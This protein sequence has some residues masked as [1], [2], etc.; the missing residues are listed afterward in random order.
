MSRKIKTIEQSRFLDNDT[1]KELNGGDCSTVLSCETTINYESCRSNQMFTTCKINYNVNCVSYVITCGV[2]PSFA[3]FQTCSNS[4]TN[5]TSCKDWFYIV[6]P[7][8]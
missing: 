5:F 4:P 8:A 2:N 3:A 7:I 1:L 6:I